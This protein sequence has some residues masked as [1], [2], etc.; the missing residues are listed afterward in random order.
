[1]ENIF[2]IDIGDT[3]R[4][5]HGII[6]PHYFK[7]LIPIEDKE[8]PESGAQSFQ[9]CFQLGK[10]IMGFSRNQIFLLDRQVARFSVDRVLEYVEDIDKA[11]A[12]HIR[13][14]VTLSDIDVRFGPDSWLKFNL[15]IAT[16]GFGAPLPIQSI[17]IESFDA[18]GYALVGL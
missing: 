2:S 12:E 7:W 4:D 13:S 8:E 15:A 6:Q 18:G 1:M 14:E 5:G 16:V 10:N 17:Q 11:L 9:T 3:S